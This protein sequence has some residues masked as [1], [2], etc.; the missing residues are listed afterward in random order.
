VRHACV[1]LPGH[2]ILQVSK[3]G[4]PNT[5]AVRVERDG[6]SILEAE[7]RPKFEESRPNG[8]GCGPVCKQSMVEL[9]TN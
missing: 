1:P 5:L 3:E 7:E 8:P 9:E 6:V 2:W 4:T